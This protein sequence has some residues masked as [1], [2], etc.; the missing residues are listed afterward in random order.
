[1]HWLAHLSMGGHKCWA[2][3]HQLQGS[4]LRPFVFSPVKP[5]QSHL[6]DIEFPENPRSHEAAGLPLNKQMP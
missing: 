1:M 5:R 3:T 2:H 4:S 6:L